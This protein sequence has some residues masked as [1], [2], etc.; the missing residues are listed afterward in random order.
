[1]AAALAILS[2]LVGR[3]LWIARN[4]R[5]FS[6]SELPGFLSDAECAHLIDKA[7]PRMRASKVAFAGQRG[8]DH[9]DRTSS[10]AFL[11]QQGDRIIRDIKL[12]IAEAVGLPVENQERIQIT[13]YLENQ[14]YDL[15]HDALRAAQIDPGEA[16]DRMFTAILYLNDGYQGGATWFPRIRRRVRPEKGKAVVFR[17]MKEGGRLVERLSLH[18]GEPVRGGEKWISNQWIRQHRR[19]PPASSRKP[20]GRGPRNRRRP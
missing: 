3:G 2:W 5:R 8:D 1:M 6:V 18:A 10:T 12:R 13:H 4:R 7:S 11:D 9:L 14:R 15:H 20:A 16:G 19:Q 17:N